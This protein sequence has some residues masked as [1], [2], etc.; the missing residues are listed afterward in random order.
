MSD[1]HLRPSCD[2]GETAHDHADHAHEG[3]VPESDAAGRAHMR[4]LM[5][6]GHLKPES[7]ECRGL[8]QAPHAFVDLLA[9]VTVGTTIVRV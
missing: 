8:E 7:T 5:D 4:A 9:G 1:D 2:H 6:S 3:H